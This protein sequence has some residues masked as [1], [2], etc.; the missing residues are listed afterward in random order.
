MIYRRIVEDIDRV[1]EGTFM[2][3]DGRRIIEPR[4][5]ST[6]SLI[7]NYV[8]VYRVGVM[9]QDCFL[10]LTPLRDISRRTKVQ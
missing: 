2:L 1:I 5:R 4:S 7:L 6:T 9:H 3:S 10:A 8:S